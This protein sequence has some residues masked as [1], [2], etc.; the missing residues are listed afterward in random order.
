MTGVR[1]NKAFPLKAFLFTLVAIFCGL[2]L[3]DQLHLSRGT[4]AA[5]AAVLVGLGWFAFFIHRSRMSGST[6]TISPIVVKNSRA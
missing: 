1:W 2:L 5:F 6:S 4:H 3:L